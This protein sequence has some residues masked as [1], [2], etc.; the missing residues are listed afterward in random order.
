MKKLQELKSRGEREIY[1]DMGIGVEVKLVE[2]DFFAKETQGK[3]VIDKRERN[4]GENYIE[5]SDQESRMS[6]SRMSGGATAKR[7][8]KS[9]GKSLS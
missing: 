5:A 9:I 7:I 8:E 1:Q 4:W 6:Y 3:K 2:P